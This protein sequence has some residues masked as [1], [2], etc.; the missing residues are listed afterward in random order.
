MPLDRRERKR[1]Y[2]VVEPGVICLGK[3][4]YK[5]PSTL[6]AGINPYSFVCQALGAHERDKLKEKVRLRLK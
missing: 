2:T 5:L 4:N 3:G 6:V 1:A